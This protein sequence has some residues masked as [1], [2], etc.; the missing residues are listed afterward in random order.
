MIKFTKA[1]AS[2]NDFIIV[3]NRSGRFVKGPSGFKG[4]WSDFAR[5][6]CR[7]RYSVGADGLLLLENSAR[8]DVR[9]RIFNPDGGEVE[10]CGN[11]SRC[12]VVYCKKGRIKIETGAGMLEAELSSKVRAKVKMTDPRDLKTGFSLKLSGADYE[13]HYVNTGV[14]HVVLFVEDIENFDVKRI[15][16]LIR[17]HG[18]F[19]PDGTNA[20]FA[21]LI[22]E[23]TMAVR[24]YERGVENETFSCGT[25]ACATAIMGS[26]VKG[27]SSPVDVRTRGGE[28]LKVFFHKRRDKFMDVYLE[29][30]A[31]IIYDG[32]II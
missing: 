15:G 7:R 12:V 4:T 19:K 17:R 27:L 6:V 31:R 10:M 26:I 16:G 14:P 32:K 28:V 29:G 30:E 11:G 18:D 20:N 23:K 25:G 22:D 8:A 21:A 2:G 1:V 13:A 3:D 24:T 5:T 9:M